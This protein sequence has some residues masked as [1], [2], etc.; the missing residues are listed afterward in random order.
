M[1]RGF[2]LHYAL[3]IFRTKTLRITNLAL[4]GI[5]FLYEVFSA[6][7]G[8]SATL[9]EAQNQKSLNAS[10][11]ELKLQLNVHFKNKP[12]PTQHKPVKCGHEI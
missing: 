7:L 8:S 5:R 10:E 9:L 4:E 12:S 11:K 3:N 2:F 1:V 6:I